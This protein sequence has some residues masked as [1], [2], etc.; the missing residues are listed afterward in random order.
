MLRIV[1]VALTI[2]SCADYV[3]YDGQYTHNVMLVLTALEHAF[4]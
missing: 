3:V 4:V 1:A 2:L